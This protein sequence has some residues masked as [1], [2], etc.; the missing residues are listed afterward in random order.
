MK[1][2]DNI[3]YSGI[4]TFTSLLGMIP[5][6]IG[7]MIGDFLGSV[8]FFL[9]RKHRNLTINNIKSAYKKEKTDKEVKKIAC[10][11]FQNI[12]RM[13][14][15]HTRFHRMKHEDF[16]D[17]F[18][19]TGFD[20]LKAAHA[21]GKGILCFSGHLGNW[22]LLAA[23]PYLTKI[24]FSVVYKTIESA[25]VGKY[26]KKK[27]EFT[28]V[29]LLPLHNALNEVMMSLKRGDMIGLIVDQNMRKRHR[30]VF[31]DFFGRKAIATK[32]L[33]KLALSTKAPVVPI[34]T[35]RDKK[36]KYNIEILPKMPLIQ[37]QDEEKDIFD[38]TQVYH[39]L[40]EKYIR[41]YPE[42]YFWVHNRWKTR[43]LDE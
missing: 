1:L 36:G 16:H 17:F 41:K 15:E 24:G 10:K 6:S 35:Y 9:D 25:P 23:L 8:W 38:N 30:G 43:P 29:K 37:T 19:I 22:E 12:A 13:L 18:K 4:V 20:N 26:M 31:I 7:D 11:V 42:Q 33:A 27:R 21:G 32:G 5:I 3:I 34:F 39:S 40:I 14:F 28:G 2:I